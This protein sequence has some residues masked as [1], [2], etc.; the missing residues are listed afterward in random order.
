MWNLLVVEDESIARL[1]LRY[2]VDWEKY[3]VHWKAEA[4][5]GEEALLAMEA[6]Q[7]IHI[8]LTDIRMPGMDGLAFA[9]LALERYPGVQIIFISS[10]DNFTYAKEAI[11]LGAVNY[12]HKP[13][14]DEEEIG[15]SLLK[16]SAKLEHIPVPQPAYTEEE[17]NQYLLSLLDEYTFPERPLLAELESAAYETGFRLTVFR[18]RDDAA[19][20]QDTGHFRFRSIQHLIAEF[21]MKEWGGLVFHRNYREVIWLCPQNA[22]STDAIPAQLQGEQSSTDRTDT[23]SPAELSKLLDMVRQKTLEL[24]NMAMISSVS[25]CYC[26]LEQLPKAYMEALLQLPLNEQSD[27]FIVRKSKAFIDKHLL[28]DLTLTKVAES[29][30]VSQSYLSRIFQKEIGESFSEYVIRHKIEHAQQ[31]LRTTNRKVYD[32]SAAIGYMNPHYFS[33]LFK[34][35][36]GVSPLEYRNQ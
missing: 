24:L 33:K 26:S 20:M 16:A 34:E 25:S 13:T 1:G 12:L 8:I 29:I 28:E 10:Y 30:H 18:K 7:P 21:V 14:M 4:S 23:N 19:T 35:R 32:I 36:T 9:K 22:R 6:Q 17:K 11:R 2:M 5:N 3:G 31:L 27:N 15:A